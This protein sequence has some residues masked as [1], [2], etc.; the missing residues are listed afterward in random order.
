M[1]ENPDLFFPQTNSETLEIGWAEGGNEDIRQIFPEIEWM[2]NRQASL[3]HISEENRRLT[4]LSKEVEEELSAYRSYKREIERLENES[5]PRKYDVDRLKLCRHRIWVSAQ[6]LIANAETIRALR[7]QCAEDDRAKDSSAENPK[8]LA[9]IE[10][11]N[12][13]LL[14]DLSDQIEAQQ[15]EKVTNPDFE[16]IQ[17][18]Q[19]GPDLSEDAPEILPPLPPYVF[20]DDPALETHERRKRYI[21][22]LNPKEREA[23]AYLRRKQKDLHDVRMTMERG[24]QKNSKMRE[25][26][27][28]IDTALRKP[29]IKSMPEFMIEFDPTEP[30]FDLSQNVSL[31]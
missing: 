28:Y 18:L 14:Q 21:Q 29:E 20:V 19:T 5:S 11:Q 31:A 22:T 16:P 8:E 4:D 30:A 9:A 2:K 12:T 1:R 24:M 27:R 15:P 25:L 6:K 10:S 17:N 3:E 13:Q 26:Q 23:L 7:T